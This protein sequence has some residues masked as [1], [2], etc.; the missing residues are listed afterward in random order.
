MIATNE[1]KGIIASRGYSQRSVASRLGMRDKTFYE[2]MKKGV[3]DSD[4]IEQMIQF[5]NIEN[6]MAIFFTDFGTRYAPKEGGSRI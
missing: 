1:L 2:K 5:L 3:F 4:E 6:P